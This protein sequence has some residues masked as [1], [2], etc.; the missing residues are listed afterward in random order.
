MPQP[1]TCIAIHFYNT[2]YCI[3]G[4]ALKKLSLEKPKPITLQQQQQRKKKRKKKKE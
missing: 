1:G 4:E 2:L 3:K